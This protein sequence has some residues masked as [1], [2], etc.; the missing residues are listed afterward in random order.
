MPIKIILNINFTYSHVI[1]EYTGSNRGIRHAHC[2]GIR[3]IFSRIATYPKSRSLH[4]FMHFNPLLPDLKLIDRYKI[5]GNSTEDFINRI[6]KI[7]C[8]KCVREWNCV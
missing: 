5:E 6:K 4:P 7:R 1:Y 8:R 3:T 2:H